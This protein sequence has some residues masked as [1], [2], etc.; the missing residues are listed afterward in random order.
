MALRLAMGHASRRLLISATTLGLAISGM[1]YTAMAGLTIFP[2]P[3]A[4]VIAPVLS[5]NNLAIVVALVAFLV[6]GV[7]LLVLV[8][9]RSTRIAQDAAPSTPEPEA[10][11]PEREATTGAAAKPM[12][13]EIRLAQMTTRIPVMKGGQ[14]HMI[15]AD[16]IVA[17]H[18]D[19]HYAHI[20]DGAAT[21]FC[22]LAIGELGQRLD[23]QRFIRVHRSYIVNIG[24]IRS[25]KLTR[26]SG[27]IE[28]TAQGRYTVPVSRGRVGQLKSRLS[29][30]SASAQSISG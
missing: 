3:A 11:T 26:G 17:V 30:T 23:P 18:A 16:E 20:F 12:Q 29:P 27:L 22:Q 10:S 25:A 8:P 9:D 13:G 5:P 14:L 24:R 1:H 4:A 7:F 28:L 19:A 15:A 2:H 21:Y 6:S